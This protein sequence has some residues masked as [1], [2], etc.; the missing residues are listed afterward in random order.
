MFFQPLTDYCVTKSSAEQTIAELSSCLVHYNLT[1][2]RVQAQSLQWPRLFSN[3][4][5]IGNLSNTL[6]PQLGILP[7][8]LIISSIFNYYSCCVVK[9][10]CRLPV[11]PGI[12]LLIIIFF[13]N[14]ASQTGYTTPGV[15]WPAQ[16]IK[17]KQSKNSQT[18]SHLSFCWYCTGSKD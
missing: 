6:M 11:T 9:D 17:I 2:W 13:L 8:H 1:C 3:V 16:S 14:V 12:F 18:T 15:K 10:L 4:S 5:F 7:L